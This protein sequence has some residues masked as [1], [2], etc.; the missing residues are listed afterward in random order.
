MA[1]HRELVD[2]RMSAQFNRRVI[3]PLILDLGARRLKKA[4]AWPIR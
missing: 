1:E 3:V 2:K 4:V